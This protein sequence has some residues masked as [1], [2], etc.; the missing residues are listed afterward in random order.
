MENMLGTYLRSRR[1]ADPLRAFSAKCGISHTHLESIEKG[2]DRRTGKPVSVSMDTLR[3]IGDGIGVDPLFL[4]CLADNVDPAR[5]RNIA[6]PPDWPDP[7]EVQA[8][9]RRAQKE[10][11]ASR[12]SYEALAIAEAFDAADEDT[13]TIVRLALKTLLS[14][15]AAATGT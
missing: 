12:I 1:G 11:R 8:S 2:V 13:K 4:A 9:A 3:L 10:D 14:P 5:V 6:I 7:P 15:P